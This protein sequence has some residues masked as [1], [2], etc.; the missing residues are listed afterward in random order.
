[1][2]QRL[3]RIVA[4]VARPMLAGVREAPAITTSVAE[5]TPFVPR[6]AEGDRP[7][8]NL[9]VPSI[10]AEHYFG[11]IHTAVV[12]YRKLLA[13]FPES[14]IILTD[15]PPNDA[16]LANFGDHVPI[17]SDDD[18][19]SPRQIVAFSD[20][21]GKTL[22]VRKNDCWLATAWWTAYGAQRLA[23][24]QDEHYGGAGRLAYFIQD[25]E[26]GFYPWSSQSAVALGTYRPETDI[27]VFNTK[28]LADYFQSNG[29][30]YTQAHVFEPTL[31]D[32]L[33]KHQGVA[34]I[35][36]AP[37]RRRI[38][39]YGRPST[40]RNAFGL[41]CEGL[42]SWGWSDPAASQWEVVAPGELVADIDLGPLKVRAVG[43]LSLEEYAELLSTS[44]VGVSLM[45]SPHP[46]YPPLEMAA[47]GMGVVSNR[48][49]NKDLAA[50]APSIRSMDNFSPEALASS[51][52]AEC[53]AWEGRAMRPMYR[54]S[55][56]HAF[57]R[58]SRLDEIAEIVA[59]ELRR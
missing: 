45:I 14:R 6:P 43:K 8:L 55:A 30:G 36:D 16:A 56:D 32:G 48:F 26:P 9:L 38:V 46:S 23:K 18:A 5:T 24:W 31:N 39:V 4:R 33:R 58:Q 17:R 35:S 59:N 40:P 50:F 27:G 44:A 19:T 54:M 34:A 28:L 15:S 49:A 57:L 22:P 7:R 20:R 52:R 11:G 42:R 3:A 47:F 25:F 51:L 2:K 13:A 29:L 12:F 10:N 21:Y 1:M 37:R 41:L 53:A